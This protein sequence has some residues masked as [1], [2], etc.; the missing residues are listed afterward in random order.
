MFST[1][2]TGFST[3]KRDQPYTHRNSGSRF[4]E[5][6]GQKCR[7]SAF[8]KK[9][10]RRIFFAFYK[11]FLS[12]DLFFSNLEW[13]APKF[14]TLGRCRF[15]V[16]KRRG[17]LQFSTPGP[18]PSGSSAPTLSVTFGASSPEGGAYLLQTVRCLKAPPSGE[19][20]ATNGS[21]LRG[22]R[23]CRFRQRLPPRGSWQ[24]RQLLTEGVPA[25]TA[26]K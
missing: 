1:F 22:L 6:F 2:S 23:C 8:Y 20:T 19:L 17:K 25:A 11:P 7:H 18:A 3:I 10:S 9:E 24:N 13:L 4:L 5:S 21:R 26:Q 15:S 16:W 12:G 14:S